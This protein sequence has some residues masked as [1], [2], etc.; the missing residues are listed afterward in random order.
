MPIVLLINARS[1]VPFVG[2]KI[3][4]QKGIVVIQDAEVVKVA[5]NVLWPHKS[6]FIEFWISIEFLPLGI[7]RPVAATAVSMKQY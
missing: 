3:S 1:G 7:F 4:R 6:P 2:K 5:L